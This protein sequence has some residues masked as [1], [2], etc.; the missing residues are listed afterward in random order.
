MRKV[1]HLGWKCHLKQHVFIIVPYSLKL[2]NRSCTRSRSRRDLSL[3][4]IFVTWEV[5][6]SNFSPKEIRLLLASPGHLPILWVHL[7]LL[8]SLVTLS[9][10]H[11]ELNYSLVNRLISDKL[12]AAL[13]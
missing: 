6:N 1:R 4:M 13:I 12:R 2:T 5:G 7:S 3:S 11:N 10:T 9:T 8:V